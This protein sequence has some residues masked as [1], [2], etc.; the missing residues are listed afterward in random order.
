MLQPQPTYSDAAF[1]SAIA[2]EEEHRN[3]HKEH[4]LPVRKAD[5]SE[6]DLRWF[7]QKW[8]R[9]I[10]SKNADDV[11]RV[12]RKYFEL[13]VFTRIQ[14]E[15]QSG[16]LFVPHS[17]QYDDYRDHF[18]DEETFRIDL[19]I[20]AELVGLPSDGKTFVAKLKAS[21]MKM[22]EDTDGGFPK[23]DSIAR[24]TLPTMART[25]VSTRTPLPRLT[26]ICWRS[27]ATR[28]RGRSRCA[29]GSRNSET[30]RCPVLL[31]GE[32]FRLWRCEALHDSRRLDPPAHDSQAFFR[33]TT[34]RAGCWR[35]S[36]RKA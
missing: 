4:L 31:G 23:N 12:H 24:G 10:V 5:A 13:C 20:Y 32:G 3:S 18:I 27:R 28:G 36:S 35:L 33:R 29:L 16:D 15:L 1:S 34:V 21:L 19:P 14:E 26:C 25:T 9:L 17:E 6:L 7:P 30:S 2:W 11:V 22:S 8:R